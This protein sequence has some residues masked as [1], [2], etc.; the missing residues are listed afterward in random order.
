MGWW[1][2]V[3]GT[4]PTCAR[5]RDRQLAARVRDAGQHVGDGVRAASP[6]THASR[7][8][9]QRSAAPLERERSSADDHQHHGRPGRDHRA[10]GAPAG[11]PGTRAP[12]GPGT[13]R[14]SRRRSGPSAHRRR[15]S[16]RRRPRA[17]STA[18][19]SSASVPSWR[20]VPRAWTTTSRPGARGGPRGSWGGRRARRAVRVRDAHHVHRRCRGA[21]RSRSPPDA[22]GVDP[23]SRLLQRLDVDEV[24][25]VA[26]EVA[27]A[28]G[29][30]P[31]DRD[32]AEARSSGSTPSFSSRT[33]DRVAS[34]R[35]RRASSATRPRRVDGASAPTYGRSNSP[36]RNF[37]RST[38]ATAASSAARSTRPS[39]SASRSGSP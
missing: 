34:S 19:P 13:P 10:R 9:A 15:R 24:A 11:G 8:A 26:E 33:I 29:D 31:D 3:S 14:S 30:R 36:S 20:P 12:A 35:P 38:F 22:Q 37:I 21:R 18:S 7:I 25:V 1:R 27:G 2:Y 4:W 28:V 39:A 23:A 16:R 5:H 17:A 32:P 6:G